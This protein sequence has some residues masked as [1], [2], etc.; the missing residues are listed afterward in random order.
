MRCGLIRTLWYFA[1][2]VCVRFSDLSPRLHQNLC[3]LFHLIRP[4]I[5]RSSSLTLS[6]SAALFSFLSTGLCQSWF[7]FT[8]VAVM[9]RKSTWLHPRLSRPRASFFVTFLRWW[10]ICI[11]YH[12]ISLKFEVS[13][14]YSLTFHSTK[15]R[16]IIRINTRSCG[17]AFFFTVFHLTVLDNNTLQ[18]G[19]Q[20]SLLSLINILIISLLNL[21]ASSGAFRQ[22]ACFYFGIFLG[23]HA[24]N[25]QMHRDRK[26]GT[27]A[28]TPCLVGSF[29]ND[30]PSKALMFNFMW[31]TV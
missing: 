16:F 9:W 24:C 17:T 1:V 25:R 3:L 29:S 7:C 31:V 19:N 6:V 30:R 22:F 11:L 5:R 2:Y 14:F 12:V 21:N 15:K 20:L 28:E 13:V 27:K 23:F 4:S 8:A 18:G 10:F 26:W